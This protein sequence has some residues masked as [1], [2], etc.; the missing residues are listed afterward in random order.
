MLVL[1]KIKIQIR[2]L[3]IG[4]IMK[5]IIFSL[6]LLFLQ[7]NTGSIPVKKTLSHKELILL[8]KEV[9]NPQGNTPLHIAVKNKQLHQTELLICSGVSVNS[10]NHKGETPLHAIITKVLEKD[11]SEIITLLLKHKADVNT[12]NIDG[13]PIVFT[14]IE[15]FNKRGVNKN[16]H[17]DTFKT[18][19][20][21]FIKNGLNINE[22]DSNGNTLLH[23]AG[24]INNRNELK[25]SIITFLVECG[26]SINAKNIDGRTFLFEF[27]YSF[28][29]FY[30]IP[31]EDFQ[32]N[33]KKLL[34]LLIHN[35][36]NINE[37]DSYGN[38]VL[39]ELYAAP[40]TLR[41]IKQTKIEDYIKTLYYHTELCK[42]FFIKLFIDYGF[43]NINAKNL[44]GETGL[45]KLFYDRNN[46]N[47][48]TIVYLVNHGANIN[49]QDNKGN[50][51]LHNYFISLYPRVSE[52]H[53]IDLLL[54]DKIEKIIGLGAHVSIKNKFGKKIIDI[55]EEIKNKFSHEHQLYITSMLVFQEYTFNY[56]KR[57]RDLYFPLTPYAHFELEYRTKEL[58]I[59][60]KLITFLSKIPE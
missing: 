33:I 56:I 36:L 16:S 52:L 47:I 18:I 29:N 26:A 45:H 6:F 4:V 57:N 24:K 43:N 23:I 28:K 54:F 40:S 9:I 3:I 20:R 27:I 14:L 49:D 51:P 31:K 41:L 11:Y 10:K 17:L 39:H 32:N 7:S 38:T 46:I 12:K 37:T 21:L 34:Q 2:F 42:M 15:C 58:K 48:D 35:G 60:E 25:F 19:I 8:E 13:E 44:D 30:S 1:V 55:I 50:T 59:I 5:K 22:T 53:F